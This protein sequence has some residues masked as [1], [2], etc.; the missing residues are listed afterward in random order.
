MGSIYKLRLGVKNAPTSMRLLTFD[1][2][3]FCFHCFFFMNK[4]YIDTSQRLYSTHYMTHVILLCVTRFV[5][6]SEENCFPQTLHAISGDTKTRKQ[7]AAQRGRVILA[8]KI[9]AVLARHRPSR[10]SPQAST[11]STITRVNRAIRTIIRSK[12]ALSAHYFVSISTIISRQF[13]VSA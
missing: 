1:A 7:I 5:G 4:N 9:T 6:V 12:S 10:P 3:L 8:D 11:I 13:N 2:R